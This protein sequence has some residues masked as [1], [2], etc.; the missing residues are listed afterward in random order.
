QPGVGQ[1]VPLAGKPSDGVDLVEQHQGQDLAHSRNRTQPIEGVGVVHLDGAFQVELDIANQIVQT[2]Q[3]TQI[4]LAALVDDGIDGSLGNLER[5]P[6][7]GIDK[8]LAERRQVVLTVGVD[9][10]RHDLGTFV[11]QVHAPAQEVAG[12]AQALRVSVGK[13]QVAA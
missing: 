13:G 2:I 3:Q 1:K 9:H 11:D 5:L 12:L 10:M 6:V 7:A 4:D 8:L